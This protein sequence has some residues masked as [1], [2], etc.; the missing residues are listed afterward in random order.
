MNSADDAGQAQERTRASWNAATK[1]HNRHKGDQAAR[2]RGGGDT[3]F[4]EELDLLGDLRGKRLVHVQCNSGQDSLCLARR[5]AE[6]VGVDFSDEAVAFARELSADTGIPARFELAEAVAWMA[7]TDERFDV[8]F[9]SY[10]VTGWIQD[11]QAWADGVA[12]I[13]RPG[14]RFVY[15]E[16][17]P[18][19]WSLGA[20]LDLRGGDDYFMDEPLVEP[21]GDYVAASAAGLG[22]VGE[23]TAGANDIPATSWQ[24]TLGALVTAF[25]RAG[26]AIEALRE[27]PY[28]NGCRV[29]EGL[30]W[31]EDR[32]WRFPEGVAPVP[33]MF[34]LACAKPG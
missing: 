31:G 9:A 14:G 33:L 28:A 26:L 11:L 8:A 19:V 7:R 13:L 23:L 18:L 10:G 32:R 20:A 24:H 15:V 4:R 22:G 17:H 6:V 21:V 30:V 25:A 1:N 5:G 29:Q 2:L 27:Y 12:R 34:G 3:L 16:F